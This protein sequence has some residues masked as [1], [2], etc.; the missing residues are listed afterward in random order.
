MILV[1]SAQSEFLLILLRFMGSML[2]D[3]FYFICVLQTGLYCDDT[4]KEHYSQCMPQ[5]GW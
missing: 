4:Y 2:M 1:L 5:C 3:G